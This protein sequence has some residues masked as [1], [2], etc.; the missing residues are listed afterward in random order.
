MVIQ[1]GS[2]LLN[3]LKS[4][5]E[6]TTEKFV[7]TLE[8]MV[9]ENTAAGRLEMR[10]CDHQLLL[11]T[12]VGVTKKVP[13]YKDFLIGVDIVAVA[14]KDGVRSCEEI[15]KLRATAK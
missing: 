2:S 13:E 14:P 6:N 9:L 11:P 15:K 4:W 7:N 8:G 5:E 12:F 1:P 10:A 3:R